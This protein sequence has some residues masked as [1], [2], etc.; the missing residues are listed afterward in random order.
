MGISKGSRRSGTAGWDIVE[1]N[2]DEARAARN[3]MLKESDWMA[4]TDRTMAGLEAAYRQALRD[5]PAQ[6]GFPTN[7]T[8]PVEPS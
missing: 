1:L 6:S 4:V 8:W 2:A 7:V 3:E 5:V